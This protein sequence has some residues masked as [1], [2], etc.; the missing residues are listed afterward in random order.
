MQSASTEDI[1]ERCSISTIVFWGYA[2][3][4]EKALGR[5]AQA[6]I[7]RIE[8]L[9]SP[10]QFDMADRDSMRGFAAMCRRAG[11]SIAAYHAHKVKPTGM[12]SG[13]LEKLTD[14]C[15]RQIETLQEAGGDFW[16]SHARMVDDSVFRLHENLIRFVE[17]TR[18]RLGIE[19]F[20]QPGLWVKDRLAFLKKLD[21]PQLGLLLDI[22]HVRDESGRNPMTIPG[23]S[24]DILDLCAGRLVHVHLHGFKDGVDHH[25]P[26]CQGD[27]IQWQE[28][29][30]GL[31]KTDYRGYLNFESQG[32]PHHEGSIGKMG[33]MPEKIAAMLR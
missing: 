20:I 28:L 9:E 27:G 23:G 19:N 14:A 2:P 1:R 3:V 26:L 5:I 21:H 33:E 29:M 32:L 7:D 17:G 22:G 8:L 31:W 25:P 11:V 24:A 16:A 6:G 18:V 12:G 15:K 10:E 30:R 4:D 13:D